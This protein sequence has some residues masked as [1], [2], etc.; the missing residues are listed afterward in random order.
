ML[1]EHKNI[2]AKIAA[3]SQKDKDKGGGSSTTTT[4]D[5]LNSREV[6]RLTSVTLRKKRGSQYSS[7]TSS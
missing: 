3:A 5:N 2:L 7:F 1:Q 6:S 4:R